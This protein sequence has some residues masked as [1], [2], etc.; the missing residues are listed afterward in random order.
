MTGP[1]ILDVRGLTVEFRQ[2]PRTWPRAG[3]DAG[4]GAGADGD[5]RAA[6]A[7]V[8]FEIR[9]GETLGL[10]GESGSGKTSTAL[11]LLGLLPAGA[12]ATGRALWRG[13]DLLAA[14]P[15]TL[16]SIRGADIALVP[17]DPMAALHPLMR[18]ERQV[19]EAVLAHSAAGPGSRTR[20]AA[21]AAAR[22]RAAEL[23]ARTGLPPD[24]IRHARYAFE[25]SGGMRQRALIAMAI[26]HSPA[27]LIADEPT[28]ALDATTRAGILALL[29]RLRDE[30]GMAIL[31]ISHDIAAVAAVADRVAVMCGGRIMETGPIDDICRAPR[32]PHTKAL[33]GGLGT[34]SRGAQT[35]AAADTLPVLQ[36]EGL[37]VRYPVH[38]RRGAGRWFTAV[39]DVS[40]DLAAGETLCVVGE[41]GAGKSSLARAVLRL[42][43]PAAGRI[44]LSGLDFTAAAGEALRRARRDLQMVFQDPYASLNPRR[45]IGPTITEPLRIHGLCTPDEAPGRAAGLL[46]QVGLPAAYA[47]RFPFELSGGERQRVAIARA[48]ALEPRVIVLDEPVSALDVPTRGAIIRLLA[49]LQTSR[50]VAYLLIAHD[51]RFVRHIADRVAVMDAGRLVETG[52]VAEIFERP[53]HACT[54]ALVGAVG[55]E[56]GG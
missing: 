48:L 20:R 27:L 21:R 12:R 45:R 50:G 56:L 33:V 10:I 49:E 54:R 1:P 26:A 46:A 18:V 52:T 8:D 43:E 29:R 5:G 7:G 19:A 31:L 47:D 3:A 22:D 30:S 6:V 35:P 37:T 36:V 14:G 17:Q 16:R 44:G 4:A 38:G 51:L 42:Q 55:A 13:R 32:H 9:P 34:S 25:W 15:E 40:L 11:A 28:A 53:G 24:R 23:L 39:D 41:S 2:A